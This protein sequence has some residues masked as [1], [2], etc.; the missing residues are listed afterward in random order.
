ME[1]EIDNLEYLKVKLKCGEYNGSDIMR[2]WVAIEELIRF[3]KENG[4]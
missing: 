1:E 3:K 4:K 2:A